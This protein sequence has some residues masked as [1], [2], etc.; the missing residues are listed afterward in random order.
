MKSKGQ[1]V[2]IFSAAGM[3][4]LILD[5]NTAFSGAV[6][7]IN[8]CIQTLIPSLFPFFILSGLMTN[9]FSEDTLKWIQPFSKACKIPKGGE[10]ILPVSI[11]GGY[12]VGAQNIALLYQQGQISRKQAARL[13]VFCNNAGPAFIFGV[14]GHMFS[15]STVPWLLWLIQIISA[16]LVGL[17]L[18]AADT[19][20]CIHP[21]RKPLRLN[22]IFSQAIKAQAMVCGWVIFMGIV[23]SYLEVWFMYLF[24][25]S[26][27]AVISGLLEL[28]N[29]CMRLSGFH[30]E[31]LR[32]LVASGLL[33]FGGLC[34]TLQTASVANG[35][36]MKF[37]FPGKILQCSFSILLSCLAQ[38]ILPKGSR[39]RCAP[40]ALISILLIAAVR[41][42]F[43]Y[44]EKS[45][46]IP[47]A[48]GV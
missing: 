29:G 28:S 18:P 34:V 7:G 35:I 36:S 47:E 39:I 4:L 44:Y 30:T 6:D 2:V 24:P 1:W 32:F 48:I 14:L 19:N 38:F 31:G 3:L 8:L 17:L 43:V 37:Y 16:F 25:F 46:G 23:L 41:I 21:Q 20:R 13:I 27:Q 10:A 12:P 42:F 45:S 22:D 33:S 5:R 15:C 40:V 11:L 26:L 9:A